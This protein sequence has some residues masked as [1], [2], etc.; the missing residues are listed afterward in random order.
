MLV[1]TGPYSTY[2]AGARAVAARALAVRDHALFV[3]ADRVRDLVHLDAV[4][5][6]LAGVADATQRQ[7]PVGGRPAGPAGDAGQDQLVDERRA[8]TPRIGAGDDAPGRR[9]C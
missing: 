2:A 7:P 1:S 8:V 4:A 9:G 3:D 6:R 5:E